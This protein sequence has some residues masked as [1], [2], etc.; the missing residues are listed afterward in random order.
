MNFEADVAPLELF[1]HIV[2]DEQIFSY[3]QYFAQNAASIDLHELKQVT[4][5]ICN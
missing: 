2:E 3:Y 5:K 1:Q 4:Y